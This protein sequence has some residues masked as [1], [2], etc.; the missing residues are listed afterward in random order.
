MVGGVAFAVA[1]RPVLQ[2]ADLSARGGQNTQIAVELNA[3]VAVNSVSVLGSQIQLAAGDLQQ[4]EGPQT[5]AA[6]CGRSGGGD[7]AAGDVGLEGLEAV[8]E[9]LGLIGEGGDGAAG[10]SQ[11]V[12]HADAVAA[13]D[14]LA[15][16][17]GDLT[18]GD[19]H[20]GGLRAVGEVGFA[21]LGVDHAALEIQGA[22]AHQKAAALVHAGLL[23]PGDDSAV[24]EEEGLG[25]LKTHAGAVGHAGDGLHGA[26]VHLKGAGE[27]AVA[28]VAGAAG[29]NEGTAVEDHMGGAHAGAIRADLVGEVAADS[30]NGGLA[31]QLQNIISIDAAASVGSGA[32]DGGENG[33]VLHGEDVVHADAV[34][35]AGG[36]AAAFGHQDHVFDEGQS[37]HF[38]AA[39]NVNAH[40][41]GL[42]GERTVAADDHVVLAVKAVNAVADDG[43][44][45]LEDNVQQAVAA[46]AVVAAG[47][48]DVSVAE[49]QGLACGFVGNGAV[50][51]DIGVVLAGD[52][53]SGHRKTKVPDH[54]QLHTVA[55]PFIIHGGKGEAQGVAVFFQ[56]GGGGGA[57]KVNG[58]AAAGAAEN[59]GDF[60]FGEEQQ[61]L[62]VDAVD[63]AGSI[64]AGIDGNEHRFI[65]QGISV[66]AGHKAAVSGGEGNV[67][68]IQ[69]ELQGEIPEGDDRLARFIQRGLVGQVG[70]SP[71][72]SDLAG[73]DQT[74]H[75]RLRGDFQL[76]G[77]EGGVGALGVGEGGELAFDVDLGSAAALCVAD[78]VPILVGIEGEGA[79]DVAAVVVS[80]VHALAQ[81]FFANVTVVIHGI[82]IRALGKDD[83]AEIATMVTV[84]VHADCVAPLGIE[85]DMIRHGDGEIK[86][87]FVGAGRIGVPTLE[88]AALGGGILR[89]DR[90]AADGEI[91]IGDLLDAGRS[92][93]DNDQIG[94]DGDLAGGQT[95]GVQ[96]GGAA[97]FIRADPV[98]L[99]Q[100]N[101]TLDGKGL[102]C[103][104]S[105]GIRFVGDRDLHVV[106]AD[107]EG[108][109]CEDAHVVGGDGGDAAGDAD[110]AAHQ[111]GIQILIPIIGADGLDAAAAHSGSAAE[112]LIHRTGHQNV[113]GGGDAGDTGFDGA[114]AA[115]DA[116]VLG[117][118]NAG[119]QG[120]DLIHAA[121]DGN[122]GEDGINGVVEG[123]IVV[124]LIDADDAVHRAADGDIVIGIDG[125]GIIGRDLAQGAG[126]RHA[127]DLTGLSVAFGIDAAAGLAVRSGAVLVFIIDRGAGAVDVVAAGGG[128]IHAADGQIHADGVN[129]MA[130]VVV[131]GGIGQRQGG[132]GS[133]EA[134]GAVAQ[135][136]AG[137][138]GSDPDAFHVKLLAFIP[139][140]CG[141]DGDAA[142]AVDGAVVHHKAGIL[143]GEGRVG[144]ADHAV[145]KGL[146]VVGQDHVILHHIVQ[147]VDSAIEHGKAAA[148]VAE[149]VV[150]AGQ[151]VFG[152]Q[153]QSLPG[154]GLLVV[155]LHVMD[156]VF[157]GGAA[158]P[159]TLFICLH[160]GGDGGVHL[161]GQT[162]G[163]H[164]A[165]V[166]INADTL[167]TPFQ[168]VQKLLSG[169]SQQAGNVAKG[170]DLLAGE[171]RH[172]AADGAVA[173][174]AAIHQGNIHIHLHLVKEI[175]QRV[176]TEIA[177]VGLLETGQAIAR[178]VIIIQ[179]HLCIADDLAQAIF[180]LV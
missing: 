125:L 154:T 104:D 178:G 129:A 86:G 169:D 18:A 103:G 80:G 157:A 66:L 130:L 170:V 43:V 144:S 52:G 140:R 118:V 15:A 41:G 98:V 165:A 75:I 167:G 79:A 10:D 22:V 91:L 94:A 168:S 102:A 100:G 20:I 21:A 84:I 112:D 114:D 164:K 24:G 120:D 42:H 53:N 32:A 19:V 33:V 117:G 27:N 141:G 97:I 153:V 179:R 142:A 110:V 152:F 174:T 54:C 175:V 111:D 40:V 72:E 160:G 122:V 59:N 65:A 60:R 137:I 172:L 138:F 107:E 46:D 133:V 55:V 12:F 37:A 176:G 92:I 74:L 39:G 11:V 148:Q 57:H 2:A 124:G 159:D 9:G 17:G 77:E 76:A 158:G 7:G 166:F 127:A 14:A 6:V 13:P 67:A 64:L 151:V 44:F 121:A 119:S 116:D 149:G 56:G 58:V 87:G 171:V 48:V 115:G 71:G 8:A 23:A 108:L 147:N 135:N 82:Q 68:I 126:E 45:A 93:E 51:Q 162:A 106:P 3:G 4:I 132:G 177:G 36:H 78:G 123:E 81:N 99:R 31:G 49:G 134:N 61:R 146:D 161:I 47:H 5:E 85:G 143:G 34:A 29:G 145:F 25:G 70:V 89:L 155:D 139:I 1:D 73:G 50:A 96:N 180:D 69:E 101:G 35:V 113:S 26:A 105:P 63:G 156:A 131:D 128:G 173:D 38:G 88:N 90:K 109:F 163:V 62:G 30:G 83:A 136:V 95:V 16:P 28:G 150:V